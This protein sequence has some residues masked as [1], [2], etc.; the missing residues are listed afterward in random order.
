LPHPGLGAVLRHRR[1][2]AGAGGRRG[3]AA[4]RGTGRTGAAASV[5]DGALHRPPGPDGRTAAGA[6][7]YPVDYS[8]T[9]GRTSRW[10]DGYAGGFHYDLAANDRRA[11]TYTSEPLP[12][13]LEVTGHP[14]VHLWVTSTHPDGAFFVY[15]SDVDAD[16]TPHYVTEGVLRASHRRR[17]A[18]PWDGAGLPHHA[19]TADAV[20]PLPD[21]PVE[22]VLDLHPTS[23]SFAAGRRLRISITCCDRDN[24]SVEEHT[25]APVVTL[26]RGPRHPSRVVLPVL[27]GD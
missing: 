11:L 22:L 27:P 4:E 24:A 25:P 16:G 20:E 15:L 17:T 7:A 10:A 5:N 6:D 14:L 1:L 12:Q 2:A 8:A 13:D 26:H 21:E 23:Y 19:G 3:E 9:S 18:A